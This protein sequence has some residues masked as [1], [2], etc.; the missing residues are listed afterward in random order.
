MRLSPLKWR[1]GHGQELRPHELQPKIQVRVREAGVSQLH[2]AENAAWL[3]TMLVR[4]SVFAIEECI[5]HRPTEASVSL[6]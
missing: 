6:C 5:T 1:F 3:D 4:L 2:Q